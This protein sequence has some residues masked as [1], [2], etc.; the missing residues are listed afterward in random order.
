M[1]L[2][3]LMVFFLLLFILHCF[4]KY[5]R[6]GRL[7]SLI[8]GP[9]EYPILGN[10]YHFF[11]P[12]EY[13]LEKF[14]KISEE[15]YPICKLW[16]FFFSCVILVHPEDIKVLMSSK[17][18]RDKSVPYNCIQDWLS[19]GLLTSKG[20]KW[21]KRRKLLTPIF[22]FNVLEDYVFAFNKEAQ[23]LINSLK[24]EENDGFII[25]DVFQLIPR[26]TLNTICET[27][28]GTSL[29][30]KGELETEYR[31]ALHAFGEIVSYR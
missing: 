9:K 25:K 14:W 26:H 18:Y 30:G 28:L 3:I 27:I 13:L 10:F 16:S 12:S 15:F 2:K 24:E 29:R 20:K 19:T 1:F 6:K 31:R 4:I 22:H 8:P 11:V 23:F 17:E 5:G 21:E 7:L